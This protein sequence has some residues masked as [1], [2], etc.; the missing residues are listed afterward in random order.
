MQA[1][2]ARRVQP[3]AAALKPGDTRAGSAVAQNSSSCPDPALNYRVAAG[4]P[5]L[6]PERS[7]RDS[8]RS[9]YAVA[10][11]R[12]AEL[13]PA[14]GS[15]PDLADAAHC[16]PAPKVARPQVFPVRVHCLRAMSSSDARHSCSHLVGDALPYESRF[17][18]VLLRGLPRGE[19]LPARHCAAIRSGRRACPSGAQP[20][21]PFAQ[22]VV[23]VHFAP[24]VPAA[25]CAR[26]DAARSGRCQREQVAQ[27]GSPDRGR[28][29]D[30]LHHSDVPAPDH[31][32]CSLSQRRREASELCHSRGYWSWAA[33]APEIRRSAVCLAVHD[34]GLRSRAA[35]QRALPP[36]RDQLGAG[37]T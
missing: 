17:P 3:F 23:L 18:A 32:H 16:A 5:G 27:L 26:A 4:Y 13:E 9:H 30:G 19:P 10:P 31:G 33:P 25:R 35:Q 29:W 22:A 36:W 24:L 8:A 20:D 21:G 1:R 14:A 12:L 7:S 11:A 2:F 37:A 28:C 6:W 15:C 34:A